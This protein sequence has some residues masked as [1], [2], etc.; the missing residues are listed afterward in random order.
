LYPFILPWLRGEVGGRPTR[1]DATSGPNRRRSPAPDRPRDEKRGR[2]R[3]QRPVFGVRW[4]TH[5]GLLR[6]A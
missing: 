2:P 4:E 3:N 1:P 5:L 6:S